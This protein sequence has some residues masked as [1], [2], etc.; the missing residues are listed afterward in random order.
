[1]PAAISG[2]ASVHFKFFPFAQPLEPDR[3]K[4]VTK[5]GLPGWERVSGVPSLRWAGV[6]D[7]RQT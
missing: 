3:M 2:M 7:Y 1:M 6:K 5:R 4:R